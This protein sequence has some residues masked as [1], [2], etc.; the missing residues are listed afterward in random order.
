M[1]TM[2][3][4][5]WWN[6]ERH[7]GAWDRVKAAFRRDWEQTKHDFKK[8]AGQELNQDVDDTVKQAVGKA[9]VPPAGVPNLDDDWAD[10]ES[11]LRYGVGA[12]NQY[13][14]EHQAWDERLETRLRDEWSTLGGAKSWDEMKPVIRRGWDKYS[15]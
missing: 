15:S 10:V 13:G 5:N 7:G 8:S 14:D 9:E 3:N 2:R 4:P 11:G 6:E 12:H 1:G